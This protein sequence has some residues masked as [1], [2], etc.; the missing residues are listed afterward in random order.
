MRGPRL[1]WLIVW[2]LCL[3]SYPLYAVDETNPSNSKPEDNKQ[4]AVPSTNP[5]TTVP[6]VVIIKK[7]SSNDKNSSGKKELEPFTAVSISAIG[8]LY[9]KQSKD[10][11]FT[12]EAP[13][14]VLPLV[15]VYVKEGTLY[16]DL[17]DASKHA[18]AKINYYINVKKIEKITSYSS[19]DIF[20]KDVLE[21]DTLDLS[22]GNLGEANVRLNV[23]KVN[24][25]IDSGG[26]ITLQGSATEQN[27]TINGAGEINANRLSGKT[28]TATIIG[29]GSIVTEVTD[30]LSTTIA[31]DGEV[32]YCGSPEINRKITGKG[33]VE[34]WG[35]KECNK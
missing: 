9:I 22:I 25:K 13:D 14:D 29:S 4:N 10:E 34:A 19:A 11:N 1:A 15:I 6:G 16:I 27:Y 18:E 8:N 2:F 7:K 5:G 21:G 35:E 30:K 31:G 20:I 32:H 12:V 24:A 23:N 26:Q 3:N 17:K 28:A 33:K